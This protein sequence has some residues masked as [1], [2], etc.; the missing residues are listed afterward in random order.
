ME[1]YG[2]RSLGTAEIDGAKT[3][4]SEAPQNDLG[5]AEYSLP[6]GLDSYNRFLVTKGGVFW[7]DMLDNVSFKAK[8]LP[9]SRR[10]EIRPPSEV[11]FGLQL[12]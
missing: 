7:Y 11:I 10:R 5:T 2:E 12:P 3:C 4:S 6:T 9:L 1:A 8:V